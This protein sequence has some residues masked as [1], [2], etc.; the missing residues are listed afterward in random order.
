MGTRCPGQLN[1]KYPML[2]QPTKQLPFK[3]FV[4]LLALM[5]SMVALSIDAMLPALSHIGQDLGLENENDA[6]FVIS[7]LF[8]GLA[9][10]QILYGPLSDAIGRKSAIYI[11]FT[12]FI[13]GCIL[14]M[15]S[16]DFTMMLL[17]RALQGLGAAGPRIV[18][19][20]LVRDG[21]E[22]RAMARIMSLVMGVFILVP[23]LAPLLGQLILF[24]APWRFIFA[25]LL[26]LAVV[27][28]VWLAFRQPETLPRNKRIALTAG[29]VYRGIVE[30]CKERT[31]IGYT[32]AAGL[33]FS[34]FIGFLTSCQQIF[35]QQYGVGERFA[36]YFAILAIAI[37]AA[38]FLNARLVMRLGM[39][40]LSKRA[41]VLLTGTSLLFLL[42][43]LPYDGSPSLFILMAYFMVIF[44]CMGILFGNFNALALE[45][46][47]HI[48]GVAAAVV[49]SLTTFISL[50]FGTLIGQ[51]YNGTVFPLVIGF[52]AFGAAATLVMFRVEKTAA[53]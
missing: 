16:T 44:F 15:A 31:A 33:I 38:S 42:Y 47:G 4:V 28:F 30:T 32:F 2:P 23:A 27:A 19:I 25:A 34:A 45:K 14:S 13:A 1:R 52:A 49:G 50:I 26:G 8:I 18:T 7:A 29:T 41:L 6:Q 10:G 11:G 43:C 12:L 46:V 5:I 39:R 40:L 36:L 48:A 17:G 20:A 22:G 9:V 35:Q 24:V 3:E 21:Y 51:L 53:P 37:G